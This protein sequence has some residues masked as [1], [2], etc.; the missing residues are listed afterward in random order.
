MIQRIQTVFLALIVVAM[1]SLLFLPL[2]SKVDITTGEEVVL[3]AWSLF[4][5][6]VNEQGEAVQ[7]GAQTGTST[8][9]IG[10]L[11]IVAA[12]VA[13]YEIFQYKSRLNQMKFGLINSMVLIALFGT[14]FYYANYV[15]NGMASGNEGNY[16]AGFYMPILALLLNALANRFIKRDEDL[17]RS[18]DRLR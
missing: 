8:I 12:G 4:F 17:V 13:L 15:G 1:V 7:A 9:A 16:E 18:A 11:A 3:T 5:Q 10:I 14:S 2:W 6:T